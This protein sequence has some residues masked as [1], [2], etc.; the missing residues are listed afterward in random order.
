[1][2]HFVDRAALPLILHDCF[3]F[4]FRATLAAYVSAQ[5]R[6]RIGS[7]AAGL[8]HGHAVGDPSHVCDLGHS[9]WQRWIL[10]PLSEAR[11]RTC[12]LMD[13]SQVFNLPS[14][15]GNVISHMIIFWKEKVWDGIRGVV[16]E[17]QALFAYASVFLSV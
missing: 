10:N 11:D 5:A 7:T 17:K 16:R 8:H 1:M 3:L 14:H 9:L 12:I 6:G 13:T 15:N 4:P 2:G